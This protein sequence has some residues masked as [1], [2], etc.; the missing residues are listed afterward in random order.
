MR[1]IN[2]VIGCFAFVLLFTISFSHAQAQIAATEARLIESFKSETVASIMERQRLAPAQK[3]RLSVE[4]EVPARRHLKQNPLAQPIASFPSSGNNFSAPAATNLTAGLSF[5]G[6]T[7]PTETGAFPP[8]DMGAVGPTQ[9][10]VAVNGRIRSFNKTTGVADAVLNVDPDVFFTSVMTPPVGS[11]FTSDPRIRYDKISARWLII[12]IDVPGGTGAI[13]NRCLLAVSNTSTITAG[14]VWTFT[15]FLGQANKFF[16]YPTLGIDVNAIYI[17]GNMFSTSTSSYLG[18]NG[19]VINRA[20]LMANVAYTVY[21]F[22]DLASGSGAGPYT[23]QGVDN[24]DA[25]PTEGYF[26]GVDN[27]TFSTLMIRRVSTPAAVPTISA[28]ISLTVPTTTFPLTV[29]HLGN[30]GGING[31]LDALDDRLYAAMMRNGRLWTAHNISVN[32]LGVGTGSGIIRRNGV[33]WYELQNLSGTPALTQSGT[34]FDPN[35]TAAN[36]RWYSIPS[37]MISGQGHAIVSMSS[38]GVERANASAATRF[39]GDALGTMQT[40]ILT[41]TSATAY[42]PPGDPGGGGGRRWGDYSY[43]SLDPLD[44]MTMWSVNQYCVGTN[45]FG[46]DVSKLLAPLPATPSVCVPAST[47]SGQASVNVVLT[48]VSVSGSGFYDPGA[49]L[50]APALPYN[51]IAASVT[52]GVTV[53]SITYTSPTSITLNLN[54]TAAS[55]GLQS[56]TVTNPDGQTMASSGGIL[57][58]TGAP[59]ATSDLAITKTDGVTTYTPGGTTTYTIVASNAGPNT[60]TGATVTD[61]FPAAITSVTWTAVYAGGATGPANGAGNINATVNLPVGGTATFTAVCNISGAA[62]GNLVNTATVAVP[63]GDTDPNPAN[64][65]STDT[66]TQAGASCSWTT[67][68]VYPIPVLDQT[69]SVVGTN[70]YS[71][72]GVSNSAVV[73]NS[74]KFDGTTW[75]PILAYPI[76]VEYPASTGDGTNVFIVG[77]ALTGTGVPQTTMYRYNVALNTYT[78]MA[79]CNIATWNPNAVYLNGKIYKFGGTTAVTTVSSSALE[80]YDIAGNSWTAGANMPSPASFMSGFTDGVYIYACGG[81]DANGTVPS[82]KTYRYNVATNTWDD[83]AIADL[84]ATRWGPAYCF[85]NG[86]G[87]LAGGYVGGAATANISTSAISWSPVTN[88]WTTLANMPA[89]RARMNGGYLCGS[90]YIVGGRS[91]ASAAFVGTNSNHKYNCTP[92]FT[93]DLAITKT[94]GV[95]IY[96]PGGTTTYT[97]V[98]SNSGTD[99]V[100]GALVTDN[101]PAAI[102]SVTWTAVYAGGASG[103]ASGAGNINAIVNLPVGGTATFTA[104][105]NISGAASGNLVNTATVTVPCGVT[106]PTPANNSAT[107]TDTQISADLAITKTDGVT[108]YTPG[109]STTYTIVASNA[110]PNA[111]TGATVTDN[112]PAFITAVTWTAVYAGGATGP[113]NGVGNISATINIPVGGTATFTAVCTISGAASGN[114]VNTATISAPAGYNEPNPANNSATDTDTQVT[115]TP[116]LENFDAVTVP[117][118]PGGWAATVG[119]TCVN[120]ARWATVNTL[121]SSAPNSAFVNDP[122]CISDEYLDSRI[123]AVASAPSQLIFRNN[124][125]LESTFDGMVLEISINGGAFTDIITAGGSF[126]AGGYNGTISV[127][128]GSPILGR[129]AWTGNS[130][131]FITTTV[132]LPAA[133]QGQNVV[134]RWRRATDSSVSGVGANID[135]VYVIASATISYAGSPYCSNAGTATVTRTGAAG[136]TY[137]STAGLTINAANG[138]VTLGTSTAGTYTVTYTIAASGGCPAFT[139][140]TS[141]TITATPAATI[142]YAGSPY[143]T[144]GGTATVTQTGTG[145]GTYSSTAGLT[146]NAANGDVTLGTSTP[147]TYT[148]TYTIA[149]G[150]GCPLF[151]TT[152]SIT[153]INCAFPCVE[154]FDGVVVPA[155]PPGWTATVGVTCGG[156]ARWATVNTTSSSAPNSA[157]VNDPNCISDEYLDSRVF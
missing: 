130:G 107:D 127:N 97:I 76:G 23:P 47:A 146:L 3:V 83:A 112:F 32:N 10:I 143:C 37:I 16:D 22:A 33:R 26:I 39:S 81:L 113:A 24:F 53:N 99:G 101:F 54:T 145:G 65:T 21:T 1:K 25:A 14:T 150:G 40:P 18:T 68:T 123:F 149:A 131:G 141:I 140:T 147:G 13:A 31:Q 106:D 2:Y 153:I 117:N 35:A 119:A 42:N 122:N 139:T 105:C 12:I 118:L 64:N 92:G 89:D 58:I 93:S 73:T 72:A 34:I 62:S 115:P 66:D 134:F 43:V 27:A 95:T 100:F 88:T 17:G 63:A 125:N 57:T 128:F 152:A 120:T 44:D 155:L 75:T 114:L 157:F 96:T 136:G 144:V 116:C 87:I 30:T 28:N 156:T 98:A 79:P 11:N 137:S 50:A 5:N 60:S 6:V 69:V 80:I 51:H 102:S 90:F 124:Y 151:T 67:S 74:Y 148:V 20:N 121:S 103:P 154:N 29:P 56:I 82:L 132:N 4:K 111:V 19:Y 104:I 85:F 138:D 55:A 77:G 109:G 91:Q 94:D 110:G 9:Y 45:L 78:L 36:A 8:D 129:Q 84:P 59:A 46:C 70:L 48:G 142:A 135:D 133:A 108:T 52:G 71:F 86:T 126:V 38:G 41:T 15:Q 49:N 7:G 61:N